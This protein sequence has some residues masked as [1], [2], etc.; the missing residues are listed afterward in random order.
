MFTKHL[1]QQEDKLGNQSLLKLVLRAYLLNL[2]GAFG[3]V[4]GWYLALRAINNHN[5][6]TPQ[7][8]EVFVIRP[9]NVD[10]KVFREMLRDTPKQYDI[11][12]LNYRPDGWTV[13]VFEPENFCDWVSDNYRFK[14]TL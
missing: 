11:Q 10:D 12:L 5:D 7:P 2:I 9:Q 14:A 4:T 1:S 3:A 8:E 13:K 6:N